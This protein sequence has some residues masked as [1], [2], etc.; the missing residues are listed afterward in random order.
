MLFLVD[1][2]KVTPVAI[3]DDFAVRDLDV[4]KHFNL[5]IDNSE[6]FET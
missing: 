5:V 2:Q 4:L 3:F 6:Y 1:S